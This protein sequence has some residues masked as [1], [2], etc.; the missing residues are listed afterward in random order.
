MAEKLTLKNLLKKAQDENSKFE[1]A[2]L[3]LGRQIDDL[4]SEKQKV[5]SD[6]K[7]KCSQYDTLENKYDSNLV[8]FFKSFTSP[9]TSSIFFSN[10]ST[11]SLTYASD[12][13]MA[14]LSVLIWSFNLL[15]LPETW[16]WCVSNASQQINVNKIIF[17]NKILAVTYVSWNICLFD[18]FG[19][20]LREPPLKT[21][22][23]ECENLHW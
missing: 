19:P 14:S 22:E 21:T 4:L 10:F 7:V 13:A 23:Q 11:V 2:K 20:I 17:S 3:G 1:V 6:Y 16:V 5:I 12:F 18:I 9:S 15:K 8:T